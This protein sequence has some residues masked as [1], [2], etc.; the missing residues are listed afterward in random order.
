M[1]I[2]VKCSPKFSPLFPHIACVESANNENEHILIDFPMPKWA[3]S[4]RGHKLH[5]DEDKG[6]EKFSK[7][8]S[9]SVIT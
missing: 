7:Q 6:K 3:C 8:N 9:S 1:S 5:G 2:T 4:A